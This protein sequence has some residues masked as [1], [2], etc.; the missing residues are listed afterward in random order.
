MLSRRVSLPLIGLGILIGLAGCGSLQPTL[1]IQT[2]KPVSVLFIEAPP[3]TLAV[4]ASITVDATAENSVSNNGVL[5]S[6]SCTSPKACGSFSASDEGGAI[7]YTAPAAIPSGATVTITATA[8]ADST[9]SISATI[10]IVLP[11]PIAVS[12]FG[13]FPASLQVN[14]AAPFRVLITNDVSANPRAKWTV[15]CASSACGSFSP[16]STTN[17]APTTFTA[18]AAIPSGT[19]VT[20]TATSVTDPTKSVSTNVVIAPQ[21]P[22]LANGTYVFQLMGP[23]GNATNFLTGVLVAKN[24]AITGGEQDTVGYTSDSE[25]DIS[26]YA[27][28]SG[29]ITGGTY[30]TTP[31]GN[32]QIVL[33][34]SGNVSE[35]LN[36]ALAS[37]QHGFTAQLYGS[38]GSGTLDL[39]T[40][41]SAPSGG[42][43]VSMYG[44]DADPVW[45]GGVLNVDSAGGISGN[46]TVLDLV[47]EAAFGIP[48]GEQ[49]L[50]ASTVSAPDQY[51]RIQFQLN[52]GQ[53]SYL[54]IQGVIGYIVDANHIRL[55]SLPLN[56]NGENEGAMGG[57]ALG[58]GAGTGHFSSSSIAGASY[59]FGAVN[60]SPYSTFQVA[61]VLT[62]SSAGAVTGTLN[63]NDLSGSQPQTPNSVHGTYAVDPTGRVKLTN[64]TD[65]SGFNYSM[66][67][68][69][70]ADGNAVL[71]SSSGDQTF[72]GQAF[73]QQSAA[74]TADSLSGTFG[75]NAGQSA[76]QENYALS[77]IAGTVTS[78][79]GNSA[80]TLAGFADSGNGAA[81]FALSGSFTPAA[82]GV[83]SGTMAGLDPASRTA[84]DSVT[85]YLIDSDSAIAI[86][87]DNSELTLGYLQLQ[88]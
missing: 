13:T 86:E 59:V 69:L 20:I 31:D 24:G 60:Q 72:A 55:I 76:Q 52:P 44:G 33:N 6:V 85:L 88:Q 61:G 78:V 1:P 62:A 2:S 28:F 10:T 57:V 67:L 34:L 41:A 38:M 29:P 56:T 66:E 15:T 83:F 25:G 64:V 77:S 73:Q 19:I 30:A 58:Q 26:P 23:G 45:I 36:G 8:V 71:L 17:E 87:T 48:D 54:P 79:P 51:G 27:G 49:S 5:Y 80:V 68:Y 82:N 32:L 12:F 75:L 39:Q 9:K 63:W 70:A 65:G 35:T 84:E 22:T 81:D 16:A 43:A 47:G 7:V 21:T 11:I 4:N 3:S 46:G 40:A 42:Y 53:S 37:G 74:F 14:T 18:P 50:A